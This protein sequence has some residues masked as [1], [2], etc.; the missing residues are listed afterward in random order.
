VMSH[1]VDEFVSYLKAY[2]YDNLLDFKP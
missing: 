2:P 1:A